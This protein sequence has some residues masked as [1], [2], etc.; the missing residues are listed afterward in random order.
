MHDILNDRYGLLAVTLGV[1][2]IV[3]LCLIIL[4]LIVAHTTEKRQAKAYKELQDT[5]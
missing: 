3:L 1:L 5:L 4:T 2:A